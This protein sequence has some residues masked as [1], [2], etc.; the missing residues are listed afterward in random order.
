MCGKVHGL[1]LRLNI[2][3]NAHPK[4]EELRV[5][6]GTLGRGKKNYRY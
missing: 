4:Q 3:R 2:L 1:H 5:F 6:N